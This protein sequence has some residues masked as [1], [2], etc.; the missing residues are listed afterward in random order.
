MYY[1]VQCVAE[2]D[3]SNSAIIVCSVFIVHCV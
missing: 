2:Y 3:A 1:N